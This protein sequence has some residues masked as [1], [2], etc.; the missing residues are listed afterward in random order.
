MKNKPLQIIIVED[1]PLA[2]EN[3]R[4]MVQNILPNAHCLGIIDSVSDAIQWFSNNTADLIFLDI[5]LADG[6]SFTIFEQVQINIPII[7][8]TAYNQYAIKAFKLNSIDYL[9]KPIKEDDLKFALQKFNS[10]FSYQTSSLMHINEI[11][12]LFKQTPNYKT[13]FT[14]QSGAKIK[15]ILVKDTALFHIMDGET[16][17]LTNQNKIY[18]VSISLDKLELLLNPEQFIRINRQMIVNF[19][20]IDEMYLLSKSRIKIK[21][22]PDPKIEV[23]VSFRKMAEFK[24]WIDR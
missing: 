22:K 2:A 3:L 20:A 14:V 23:L 1:E 9:L 5:H 11:A 17:A 16:F 4:T 8:T 18:D 13:R 10:Q 6:T 7:F 15:T 21:L 24:A 19:D 12:A